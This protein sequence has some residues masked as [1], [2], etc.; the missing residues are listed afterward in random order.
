MARGLIAVTIRGDKQFRAAM[1]KC[2]GILV[3]SVGVEL[4][5]QADMAIAYIG[6][7]YHSLFTNPKGNLRRSLYRDMFKAVGSKV[8]CKAG[9]GKGATYGRVLEYGPRK[10]RWVILP[11]KS[12]AASGSRQGQPTRALQWMGSKGAPGI[13]RSTGGRI[14]GVAYARRV[15]HVWTEA[16]KRPH[17]RKAVDAQRGRRNSNLRKAVKAA[18]VRAGKV[19]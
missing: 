8:S 17:W 14:Q 19:G 4:E 5:K 7:H 6:E 10:R 16:Q 3:H 13:G 11:G 1:T 18:L 15:V 2:A 12:L 9:W